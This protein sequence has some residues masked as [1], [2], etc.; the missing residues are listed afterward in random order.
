MNVATSMRIVLPAL[1]TVA[2]MAIAVPAAGSEFRLVDE[3]YGRWTYRGSE[4][5]DVGADTPADPAPEADLRDRRGLRRDTGYFL[6]YQFAVIGLLYIAPESVS[7]W[8][9]EQKSNYS[10][11]IWWDNVTHPT[12]DSDDFYLN[13]IL[14][15]YWGA[16]YFVRA[17]ERGYPNSAAFWY[18][19][20]LSSLYEFGAEALFE[21]PSIQDL[22]VT[23]VFGSLLG[24]YFMN[25][26]EDIHARELARGYRTTGDKWVLVLTDPLGSLNRQ[27][28]RWFGWE[29]THA[30]LQPY[31]RV[32][33]P[34]PPGSPRLAADPDKEFGVRFSLSWE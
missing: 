11:S 28:D 29:E 4:V 16:T 30:T 27:F 33:P 31:Y 9:D 19:A 18:S 21:Q 20:M 6:A 3:P 25:V 17:R 24:R 23:P 10:L 22:I 15:P 32:R 8:S 5:Q 1:L 34:G 13:Y 12:W 7:G 26:R 2:L 14:H